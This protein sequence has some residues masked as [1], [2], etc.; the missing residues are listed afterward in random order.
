MSE[1][2]PGPGRGAPEWHLIVAALAV[3][4]AGAVIM[5]DLFVGDSLN[6]ATAAVAASFTTAA[7]AIA[8]RRGHK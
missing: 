5:V 3:L 6:A 4:M 1:S 8:H 2:Q 7:V